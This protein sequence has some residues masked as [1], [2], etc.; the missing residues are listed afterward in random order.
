MVDLP[1]EP[2]FDFKKVE[3]SHNPIKVVKHLY[4]E[5]IDGLIKLLLD[6]SINE[7]IRH[8]VRK[9]LTVTIFAALD[10]YFRNCAR[11]LID[12]NGLSVASSTSFLI[13]SILSNPLISCPNPESVEN[14]LNLFDISINL[15]RMSN[16]DDSGM[17]A[18]L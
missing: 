2:Y 12:K 7:S 1:R 10:Y 4:D 18:I 14:F 3:V 5:E 6:S 15:S 8:S 9:Y 11:N 16:L 17:D 13:Y